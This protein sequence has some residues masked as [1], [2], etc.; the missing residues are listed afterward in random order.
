MPMPSK[1]DTWQIP[2]TFKGT[3]TPAVNGGQLR[4]F[5]AHL[6]NLNQANTIF[7]VRLFVEGS[8]AP[9]DTDVKAPIVGGSGISADE[10]A[11]QRALDL[12]AGCPV[13]ATMESTDED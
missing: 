7:C 13:K 4:E 6:V 2:A 3:F 10:V 5:S 12:W 1:F 9:W 11:V 8:L